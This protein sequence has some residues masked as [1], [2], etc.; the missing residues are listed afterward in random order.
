MLTGELCIIRDIEWH[1]STPTSDGG[2]T[3][4]RHYDS[5]CVLEVAD[6]A[7]A[8]LATQRPRIHFL[9]TTRE[10]QKHNSRTIVKAKPRQSPDSLK[11][12]LVLFEHPDLV[13]PIR[14]LPQLKGCAVRFFTGEL[15]DEKSATDPEPVRERD[16]KS[17]ERSSSY[18]MVCQNILHPGVIMVLTFR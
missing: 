15:R 17:Q 10:H 8:F 12:R 9:Q 4:N 11:T 6:Q 3:M 7:G 18:V 13:L 5:S 2:P 1:N 16:A 14:R